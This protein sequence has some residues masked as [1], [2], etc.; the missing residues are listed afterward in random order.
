MPEALISA[1]NSGHGSAWA[2]MYWSMP[3]GS[4]FLRHIARAMSQLLVQDLGFAGESGGS[5]VGGHLLDDLFLQR[6]AEARS[7]L[8]AHL[9]VLYR[10]IA[11]EDLVEDRVS[12][13]LD[14]R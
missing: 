2:R 6:V 8:E 4:S 14:I 3:A 11:V 1:I 5:E 10:R 13:Q 12:V 9:A 7:R